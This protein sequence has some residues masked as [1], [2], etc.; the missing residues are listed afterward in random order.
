MNVGQR[1]ETVSKTAAFVVVVVTG[2]A[3]MLAG[4]QLAQEDDARTQAE[5]IVAAVADAS[6]GITQEVVDLG[7]YMFALDPLSA[8]SSSSSK[9]LGITHSYALYLS[10]NLNG[11]EWDEGEGAFELELT[12]FDLELPVFSIHIDRLYIKLQMFESSDASGEPYHPLEMGSGLDPNVHSLIYYREIEGIATN[13]ESGTIRAFDSTSQ[14]TYTDIEAG[15][16]T[17]TMAGDTTRVFSTSFTNGRYV[18]GTSDNTVQT[19]SVTYDPEQELFYFTGVI[20]YV[21][22]VAVTRANGTEVD[23]YQQATVEFDG[24]TT[25]V[26]TVAGTRFRFDVVSGNLLD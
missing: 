2:L 1:I 5:A 16:T 21:L 3:V 19:L 23:Y 8:S 14:L 26:V 9:A 24:T 25:G 20:S 6:S 22:D 11:L 18:S 4:C 10:G 15:S 7:A 12:D 13:R 17:V